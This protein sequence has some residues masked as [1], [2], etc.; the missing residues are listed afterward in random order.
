MKVTRNGQI[1]DIT[2]GAYK[3]Q[4]ADL[5]YEPLEMDEPEFTPEGGITPPTGQVSSSQGG[6]EDDLE[7]ELETPLEELTKAEL[8]AMAEELGI[9]VDEKANKETLLATIREQ[10]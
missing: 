5:G 3:S 6:T 1:I 2:K 4:F 7:D 9:E 8:R 10:E